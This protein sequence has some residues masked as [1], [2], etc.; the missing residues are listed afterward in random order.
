MKRATIMRGVMVSVLALMLGAAG[1]LLAAKGGDGAG[2]QGAMPTMDRDQMRDQ[3]R[4]LD[5][6]MDRD[7]DMMQD[8]DMDMDKDKDKDQDKD[9]DRDRIHQD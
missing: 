6:D 4:L 9:Q 1:P 8:R 2:G 5:P 7:R 3:D